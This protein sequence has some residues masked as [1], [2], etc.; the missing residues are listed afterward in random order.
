MKYIPA[1]LVIFL[2]LLF[3]GLDVNC[4]PEA[5]KENEKSK[6]SDKEHLF[7]SSPEECMKSAWEVSWK[8][9]YR[10]DTQLFYDYLTS[11]EKGKEL[12]HLPTADEVK[13]QY[14]NPYG[15]GTGMEDCMISAGVMLSLIVD[16]Y[17]VTHQ[18]FLVKDA[19]SVFRGIQRCATDH[20]IP[21]F[22]SRGICHEDLRSIYINSSRDQ[23]THAV[24]GLWIYY[25]SPLCNDS[26]KKEIGIILSSFADRMILNVKQEND[27]DFL[28]ADGTRD[29]RGICRMWNVKGHEA[30]RLPMIYAAAWDVTGK[31]EYYEQ[32]RSY[33]KPAVEQSF[34]V[35]QKTPT[36][37]LI[38]M[39]GSF[40]IQ[41][42]WNRIQSLKNR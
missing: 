32:Y 2:F 38:Q 19:F 27:F 18:E 29:P 11:Y 7:L 25:H 8:R 14:P 15:Y 36:Y 6:K 12:D 1:L 21:G 34:L 22:L 17:H 30:A 3:P 26:V 10:S 42:H 23:Y 39:Q 20:G 9:F 40:E 16:R 24:H 4:A 31:Q 33:I 37:A 13:R 28:R 5:V 41:L 35:E